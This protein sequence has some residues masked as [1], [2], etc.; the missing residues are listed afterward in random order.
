MIA[1]AT[2]WPT[3]PG[4]DCHVPNSNEGILAPMLSSKNRISLD[5]EM[6]M[7]RV[8]SDT[9]PVYNGTR[10]NFNKQVWDRFK[11]FFLNPRR[12]QSPASIVC[13]NPETPT[14]TLKKKKKK[15]AAWETLLLS[16]YIK[17]GNIKHVVVKLFPNIIFAKVTTSCWHLA[18]AALTLPFVAQK[19]TVH[20]KVH[21][22]GRKP[23]SNKNLLF[24]I[25][26][27]KNST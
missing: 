20:L 4:S 13:T 19:S 18:F 15:H 10:F 26:K 5:I 2:A 23:I 25:F 9:C 14:S 12:V 27:L 24:L 22:Q 16:S 11:I 17:V 6:I 21:V 1:V 8:F 3:R 7:G